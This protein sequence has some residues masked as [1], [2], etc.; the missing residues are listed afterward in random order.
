MGEHLEIQ[1]TC[2]ST[3]EADRIAEALVERRLAA[4]V[5]QLPIRSTYRWQGRI[6]HDDEVLLLVKSVRA[7]FA[8]VAGVVGELHSYELPALTA[9]E[10]ADG[11][12]AYLA[13]IDAE[14]A[15]DPGGPC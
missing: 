8:A 3:E 10:I 15:D 9:V 7:R 12:E 11:T 13:W 14:T 4:C 2:G 6:E 1:I 5:Q